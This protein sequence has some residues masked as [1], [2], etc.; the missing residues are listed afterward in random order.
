MDIAQEIDK[1]LQWIKTVLSLIGDDKVTA[2]DL[3]EIT[4]HDRCALGQWLH[5]EGS[6]KFKDLPELERLTESHEAFHKLAGDL[7]TA[8][9]AGEESEA[10]SLQERFIAKSQQL[11]ESLHVLQRQV[12]K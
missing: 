4:Q 7:V 1:H 6:E 3:E 9:E 5:V 12:K 11:I 8:V 2:K 10:T